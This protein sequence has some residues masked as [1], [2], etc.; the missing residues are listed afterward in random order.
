MRSGKAEDFSADVVLKVKRMY[1]R[2]LKVPHRFVCITDFDVPGCETVPLPKVEMPVGWERQYGCFQRLWLFSQEAHEKLGPFILNTDLDLIVL[3]DLTDTI[4]WDADFCALWGD[5]FN[6]YQGCY[7]THRTGTL[8]ELWDDY[9]PKTFKAWRDEAREIGQREGF[10]IFGS[11]QAMI[12][13]KLRVGKDAD[14]LPKY[15]E[16]WQPIIRPDN[17][18]WPHAD[19]VKIAH[20]VGSMKPWTRAETKPYWDAL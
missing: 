4:N 15:D 7:L 11:D 3:Q 9:D 1:E 6:A 13:I 20:Y 8:T 14:L 12:N 19:H 5:E 18:T 17:E 10:K 2:H 16:S